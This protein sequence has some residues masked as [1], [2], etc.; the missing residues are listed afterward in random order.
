VNEYQ[1]PNWIV[2][3]P[4]HYLLDIQ[5]ANA[6]FAQDLDYVRRFEKAEA[7]WEVPL[8]PW[9]TARQVRRKRARAGGQRRGASVRCG[10]AGLWGGRCG[11]CGL[12][13]VCAGCG[14]GAGLFVWGGMRRGQVGVACRRRRDGDGS[15]LELGD[16]VVGEDAVNVV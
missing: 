8:R 16:V 10:G 11:E 1:V 12:G 7:G 2:H 4:P 14:A 5:T 3:V 13:R 9:G 15:G 6:Y